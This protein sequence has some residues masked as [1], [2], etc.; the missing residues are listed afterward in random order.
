[1]RCRCGSG[2]NDLSF[3]KKQSVFCG[4]FF[5]VSRYGAAVSHHLF[6]YHLPEEQKQNIL[7]E[8]VQ[9]RCGTLLIRKIFFRDEERSYLHGSLLRGSSGLGCANYWKG[10]VG[11]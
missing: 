3:A 10:R 2:E 11:T 5:A 8:E 6:E 9:S 7:R 4:L 1:M